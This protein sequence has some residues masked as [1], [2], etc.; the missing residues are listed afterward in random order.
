MSSDR[1]IEANRQ[2]AQRSTGLRNADG[3]ARVAS[4][5]L[6]HGLTGKQMVLS[7]E[8]PEIPSP[9]FY[10]RAISDTGR[11]PESGTRRP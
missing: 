9:Y 6:K 4:N 3:K 5:A 8:N 1:Q 10:A 2:N 11:K 7:N